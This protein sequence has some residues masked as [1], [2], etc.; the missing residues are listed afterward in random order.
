MPVVLKKD[1]TGDPVF[2]PLVWS[3]TFL[4]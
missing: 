4:S 2:W 1:Q 3:R